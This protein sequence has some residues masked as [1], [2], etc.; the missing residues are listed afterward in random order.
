M[1]DNVR[2]PKHY[3]IIDGMESIDMIASAMTEEMFK[4]FCLGNILKY[5]IRAGKKDKLQQDIDK[6]N[7]YEELYLTKK[8]FCRG[9]MEDMSSE[10]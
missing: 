1:N 7:Y 5:R 4:G 9:V 10:V 8:C 6:A 2:N 3:Q